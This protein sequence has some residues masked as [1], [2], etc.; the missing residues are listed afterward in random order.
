ML[1]CGL[2]TADITALR[3]L[4]TKDIVMEK[5]NKAALGRILAAAFLLAAAAIIEHTTQLETWQLLLIYMVPYLMAGYGT[6]MEAAEKLLHGEMLDEDFLMSIATI[7]ALCI[8]FLPGAEHQFPEAVFVMLFFQLGELFENIA[9]GKS[10]KSISGL[11]SIRPDTANVERD[12]IIGTV[13][14]EDVRIGE[15]IVIRSGERVPLD[16]VVTEGCS[17]LDTAAL[18]GESI[19]RDI[20][21]GDDIISGCINLGG[22]LRVKVSKSFGESTA[23]RILDLVENAAANKS[24]SEHFISRFAR[25]YT[26]AVVVAAVLIAFAVPALSGDFSSCFAEWLYRGLMFLIVSCPC[27]LVISVPLAFFGGIGGASRKGILVKGSNYLEALAKVGIAVFDKTGTLTQGTFRV[28]AVHPEMMDEDSLLHIA[29]HVERYSTHPIAV[30]LKNAYRHEDDGCSVESVEEIAGQG[31]KAVVNGQTVY[32]GNSK[33]MDSVGAQWKECEQP[34]TIV[35][36]AVGS[37]YAGHIVISDQVKADAAQAIRELRASGVS[38]TVMLTGDRADT[39]RI[40]AKEVGMDE[41]RAE[42]LPDDKVSEVERLLGTKAKGRSLAFIGDGIN[43]APVLARADVGIAMGALGSDAA[44]EA[45]DVVVMNDSLPSIAMGIRIAKKTIRIAT[46]NTVGAIAVK[47]LVLALA[48]VGMA[49]MWMAVFADVGITVLA[50]L[51]SMRCL[52]G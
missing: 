11:M 39:A 4:G 46:Q 17:S 45:A 38:R 44:I 8:G 9:E 13:S 20:G 26:P 10:R 48:S 6:L 49:D 41:F 3:H 40:V 32:V 15:I 28:T 37:E 7:G 22:V 1:S 23:A 14:P 21:V 25:I 5:E 12:G 34:G 27:A 43:D 50:I 18:T 52:R 2:P 51:N 24:R 19:P 36:V 29:A 33:L 30:S 31:A 42:L 16:G 47:L 35:H